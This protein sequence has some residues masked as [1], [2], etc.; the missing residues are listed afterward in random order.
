MSKI[1]VAV[2]AGPTGVG[3]TAL[4]VKVAKLLDAEIISADSMQ[5]YKK[6]DI[7]TAKVTKDEM[8][9]VPHHLIDIVEPDVNFSVRDFVE[10][11]KEAVADIISR[12]KLPLIAGGTG[13]YIDSFLRDID[14]TDTEVDNEY[15]QQ[16]ETIA[17]QKGNGYLHNELQ[18]IDPESARTI[19]PNNVKRVIR[20]LEFYKS[21]GFAISK[22]NELSK[23]KPSPYNCCYIC[24]VRDRDELYERIDKRVDIMLRDGLVEETKSLIDCGISIDST[25]MQ[26]IGY[27]EIVPYIMDDMSFEQA[28]E[29][30]K[31]SS[32]RYAKRQLTWFGNRQ[33]VIYVNLSEKRD[34][35]QCAKMC[36]Q[37]IKDTLEKG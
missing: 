7:G 2:I 16:L 33:D 28:V 24:L 1:P 13:L 34:M 32:R 9:G 23:Q 25:C 11:C 21:T 36:A 15:R 35:D 8:E 6:M 17:A 5:I 20:A 37:I 22:H 12:G 14:F 10:K 30:L 29:N 31:R 18:K 27:K 3:K 26:A 4:S 19:H